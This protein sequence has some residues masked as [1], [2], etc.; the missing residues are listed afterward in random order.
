V[1]IA[2]LSDFH[3]GYERFREDAFRQAEEALGR[4]AELADAMLIPGDIFDGRTPRP[5]VIAEAINLFRNLSRRKWNARV[6]DFVGDGSHYTDVPII[7][8]P[9]THER[10]AQ[11]DADPVDLLGLAGLLVDA[12]N[13]TAVIEA[14]GE[15]VAVRGIGGI[16]DERF[17]QVV[18]EQNPRPLEGVFN[19]FMF[20]ESLYELLPFNEQ[21]MRMEELPGGFDLYVC[22]HIHGRVE[23]NVHG[24]K[25]LIP[26]STVLTQ[27]RETEQERKG[28][29]VYDTKSGAYEHVKINSR[30]FVLQ[31]V[32]VS[33]LGEGTIV[34]AVEEGI[35]SMINAS[36]DRPVIRVVMEGKVPRG[37]SIETYLN[38]MPRKY[39]GKAVVEISR[40]GIEEESLRAAS[41]QGKVTFEKMSVK[42]IG[43][44]IF[45]ENLKQQGVDTGRVGPV[46]LL[47]MLGSDM[48]KDKIV[49][50]VMEE[51]LK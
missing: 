21:F 29:Y 18:S 32:D 47:E 45:L 13:A 36:N 8:I 19:V 17:G 7:A 2:I 49:K 33:K 35:E 15:R 39:D 11:D 5:D 43:M 16:A 30:R 34:S 41:A 10:R 28:F 44:G 46:D 3:L 27:L 40:A 25:L 12:S 38:D 6:V 22:G 26:G 42:D 48:G 37:S 4:A 31:K 24:K 14:G 9:G 51:L 23:G 20:H 1:R 50:K